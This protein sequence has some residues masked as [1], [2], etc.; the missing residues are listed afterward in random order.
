MVRFLA[1]FSTG[2]RGSNITELL[3]AEG[4]AVIFLHGKGSKLPFTSALTEASSS[5][6][7]LYSSMFVEGLLDSFPSESE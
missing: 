5:G 3:L 7:D 4:Y 6:L 1:N 2:Q